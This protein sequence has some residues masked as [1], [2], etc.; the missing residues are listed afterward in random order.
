VTIHDH[1][2]H[3][4]KN[5]DHHDG[6]GKPQAATVGDCLAQ[7]GPGHSQATRSEGE[8]EGEGRNRRLSATERLMSVTIDSPAAVNWQ[9]NDA[10]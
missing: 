1:Q 9:R 10:E 7:G 2:E 6:T 5:K 8:E 3:L 4:E